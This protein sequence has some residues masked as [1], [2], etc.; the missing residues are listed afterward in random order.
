MNKTFVASLENH[1]VYLISY[2]LISFYINVLKEKE[3]TNITL[4]IDYKKK[5]NI[6]NIVSYYE[7]IDNFNISLVI[8]TFNIKE[9]PSLYKEQCN[10]LSKC[11][12]FAHKLL[13]KNDIFV[14]DNINVIKHNSS[15]SEFVQY[16]LSKFS[17]RLRYIHL[18]N[19]VAEE[20]PYNKVN[21]ANISFV[22]GRPELELTIKDEEMTEIINEITEEKKT[23]LSSRQSSKSKLSLAASGFISYYLLGFLTAVVTLLFLTM[24]VK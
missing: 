18:D 16:F 17:D 23:N 12:N 4:D 1:D 13:T 22:V 19:L 24:I 3:A 10:L 6:N 8:P 5:N 9:I 11:I 15:T 7:K 2:E 20:V 21:A 14:N